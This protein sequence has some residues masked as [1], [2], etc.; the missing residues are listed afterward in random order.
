MPLGLS[1][2]VSDLS[3]SFSLSLLRARALALTLCLCCCSTVRHVH[4]GYYT[5][6]AGDGAVT[7]SSLGG[8]C[9]HATGQVSRLCSDRG[10]LSLGAALEGEG[11]M[12]IDS[13]G[14]CIYSRYSQC[15]LRI[16]DVAVENSIL[17]V[18][19][20]DLYDDDAVDDAVHRVRR[21]SSHRQA[22]QQWF[23][24]NHLNG[25]QIV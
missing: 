16:E 4:D 9:T 1:V 15:A 14:Q 23:Q 8:G 11:G 22:T 5:A 25:R 6:C 10:A 21:D 3:L 18:A 17:S 19:T 20:I 12:Q 13:S 24:A 2:V 7:V